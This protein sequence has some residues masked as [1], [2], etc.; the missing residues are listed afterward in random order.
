MVSIKIRQDVAIYLHYIQYVMFKIFHYYPS[1]LKMVYSYC[2]IMN[3]VYK[4]VYSIDV[5][6]FQEMIDLL[7]RKLQIIFHSS[8]FRSNKLS[9]KIHFFLFSSHVQYLEGHFFTC[10]K[11]FLWSSI[12]INSSCVLMHGYIY[13]I[14]LLQAGSNRYTM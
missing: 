13:T 14:G 10:C 2:S 9:M 5:L 8:V 6:L 4:Y 1:L 11:K 3:K 12:L 7:L